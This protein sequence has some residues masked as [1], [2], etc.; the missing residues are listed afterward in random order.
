MKTLRSAIAAGLLLAALAV[1]A[2][3]QYQSVL[4]APQRTALKAAVVADNAANACLVG[5]DLGCLATLFNAAASPTFYVWR[6]N[7]P[8]DDIRDQIAWANLTPSDM[9]DGT[10]AWL[11]R[12]TQAQSKQ[13]SLQIILTSASGFIS[14]ADR[15]IRAGLQDAL[16]NLATGTGGTTLAA[17]WTNVRDQALARAATR[18]EKLFATTTVQQDGST[19]QKSATMVFEGPIDYHEF[20]LL[21]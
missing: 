18:V 8:I 5:G 10:Q 21:P 13:F 19:A 6:P 20:G 7:V 14:G 2:Q 4:T 16:T 15:N 3:A 17:G 1:P 11:N 12:A 9:P